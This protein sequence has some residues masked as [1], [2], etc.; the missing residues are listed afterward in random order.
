MQT[1]IG[2]MYMNQII[3]QAKSA[4]GS[5]DNVRRGFKGPQKPLDEVTCYKV[6]ISNHVEVCQ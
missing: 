5:T 3:N 6:C 4:D 2:K 1:K